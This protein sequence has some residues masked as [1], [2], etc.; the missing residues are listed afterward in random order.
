MKGKLRLFTTIAV[1]AVYLL[2]LLYSVYY[3]ASNSDETANIVAG[4]MIWKTGRSGPSCLYKP[5]LICSV[6]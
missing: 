3:N 4:V 5:I 2:T 1:I 6:L